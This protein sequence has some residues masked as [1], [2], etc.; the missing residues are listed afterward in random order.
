[1][2]VAKGSRQPF[3]PNDIHALKAPTRPPIPQTRRRMFWPNA[4]EAWEKML[5][6][7]WRRC[8]PSAR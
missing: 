6:T 7:G 1:M 4:I 8:S 5:K 2:Q 3:C